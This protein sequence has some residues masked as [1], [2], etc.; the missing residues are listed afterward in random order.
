[1][2]A[3]LGNVIYWVG[4]AVMILASLVAVLMFIFWHNTNPAP[5]PLNDIK[6][7]R[8][9]MELREHLLGAAVRWAAISIGGG[10]AGRA[11]R[12]ILVGR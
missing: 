12:Y 10:L 4:L 3:R 11:A 2:A 8:E 7:Y 6:A 9:T 5:P 1:M